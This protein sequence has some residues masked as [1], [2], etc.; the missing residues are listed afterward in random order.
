MLRVLYS[1]VNPSDISPTI[2]TFPKI[3][4]SDVAAVVEE[5]GRGCTRL[6]RGDNVFGDIGANAAILHTGQR[7]K[8]LGAYAS[9]GT[10]EER[11]ERKA[12]PLIS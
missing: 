4:G 5:T 7:T 11:R 10:R 12:A 8:E 2:A 6:K 3:L 1:S 9:R